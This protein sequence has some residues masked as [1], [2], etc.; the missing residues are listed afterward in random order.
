HAASYWTHWLDRDH[1]SGTGDYELYHAFVNRDNRP[2]CRSGY[3]PVGADCRIKYSKKPWYEGNEVI[4]ECHR[5]T[6]WGIS[7][8]N[9]FQP[10]RWCNDYEVRFLCYK[11]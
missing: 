5:C 4:R 11:P 6:D 7:C 10:D 1:P 2:P 9:K 8:V 3:K